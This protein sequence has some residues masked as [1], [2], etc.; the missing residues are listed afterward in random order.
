VGGVQVA[1]GTTRF[2]VTAT[3]ASGNTASQTYDVDQTTSSR[4]YTFDA[5]GNLASDST[6]TF[7]W[8]ARN[9]LV[10][11]TAGGTT[12]VTFAY[13][14]AGRRIR[15]T[16]GVTT[17]TYILDGSDVAEERVNGALSVRYI[18]GPFV[19]NHLASQGAD[20]A[21]RF[22]VGDILG[23][24]TDV[25]D[26]A[27]AVIRTIPYDPWGKP[28]AAGLDST[29]AFTGRTWDAETGLYYYRARYY[30][31][32]LGRFISEDPIRFYGGA[33]LYTYTGNSPVSRFDPLGLDWI[34]YTGQNLTLYGGEVGNQSKVLKKCKATSGQPNFQSPKNQSDQD[35]G[36]LPEGLYRINLML[37]PN[38]IV[39]VTPNNE[40]Y[41]DY[42][43]QR[44]PGNNPD[45]DWGTWRARLEKVKLNQPTPRNN[46]YLH[47]SHKGYTHG[48]VE[49]CDDLY[50]TMRDYHNQGLDYLPV[51]IRYTDPTTNGGTRR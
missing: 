22:F 45:S 46:F 42:G 25:T 36:P 18:E 26:A 50:N 48:C 6:R 43:V 10:A 34:E 21:S 20:G 16:A 23:S 33:N 39:A 12:I 32:D 8:D 49:T 7:V 40:S 51:R 24:V 11:V 35:R 38:R 41:A 3:D 27:G 28:D 14:G 17:I 13:D 15:K 1:A 37:N 9:Q 19:D 30:S 4:A 5:N 44:L 29:Y 2:T 47:N 31:P